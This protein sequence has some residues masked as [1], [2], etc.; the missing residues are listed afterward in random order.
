MMSSNEYNKNNNL[1]KISR[2]INNPIQNIVKKSS[3]RTNQSKKNVLRTKKGQKIILNLQ[4][5]MS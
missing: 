1:L 3:K 2:L 4:E 5:M